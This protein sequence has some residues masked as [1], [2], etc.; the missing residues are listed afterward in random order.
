MFVRQTIDLGGKSESVD[1][2]INRFAG[3]QTANRVVVT[4]GNST[5]P[6]FLMAINTRTIRA[7][8]S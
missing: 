7:A 4:V 5:S 2:D 1:A 8:T 6:I 3:K